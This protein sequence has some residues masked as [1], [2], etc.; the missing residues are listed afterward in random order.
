MNPCVKCGNEFGNGQDQADAV[1]MLRNDATQIT[2]TVA[3]GNI[4]IEQY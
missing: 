3:N 2:L 1:C 4:V